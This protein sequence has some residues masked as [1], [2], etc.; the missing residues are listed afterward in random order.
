M[1]VR[2]PGGVA[3]LDDV[4]PLPFMLGQPPVAGAN[5]WSGWNA[6]V[7][8]ADEYLHGVRYVLVPKFPVTP[9]WTADLKKRYGRY[10]D[11]HFQPVAETRGW[12]LLDRSP[13]RL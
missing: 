9:Q 3:V 11:D 12:I 5:L 13:P 8:P 7:R 4:N 10:L 1:R 2:P 6:P